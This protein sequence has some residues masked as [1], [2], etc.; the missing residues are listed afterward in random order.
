MRADSLVRALA[1]VLRWPKMPCAALGLRPDGVHSCD[2]V[3]W[4]G[5]DDF[6]TER[7]FRWPLKR[8]KVF[9][10]SKI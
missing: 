2:E 9:P 8:D 4:Q 7:L 5:T 1:G 3:M 6:K 10:K